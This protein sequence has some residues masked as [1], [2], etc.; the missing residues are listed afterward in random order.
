MGFDRPAVNRTA[1]EG[2]VLALT[3]WIL[4]A[5]A[6]AVGLATLWALD[7][8]RNASAERFRVEDQLAMASTRDT[9]IYLG[10]TRQR[11]RA[12]L[13]VTVP[14]G[15]EQAL[16]SLDDLGG[17]SADPVGGELRL[18]GRPYAGLGGTT[19]SIQDE[20]GLFVLASPS[21]ASLDGFLAWAGVP[22]DK[23]AVLRD[24][25]LDYTD[26]D[27]LR[28]LNGAEKR[29]YERTSRPPP[30]NRRLLLPA[31]VDRILGWNAL[32]QALREQL[33]E[34]STTF[35]SGALNLNTV[36]E[37]LLPAWIPG[38]PANCRRLVE[39]RDQLPFRFASDVELL[40]GIRLPGD[41]GVD[42]RF[43][44]DD[45]LRFTFWSHSGAAWRIHVRFTPLADQVGPWSVLA[46]HP[47]SRPGND[48][49]A[50]PTGSDLFADEAVDRP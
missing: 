20:A 11:T 22:R 8:V 43:L 39:R 12:G 36:P 19:F 13:A 21:N 15:A 7:A 9:L 48:A 46:L 42:Y 17:L 4:A 29:E 50:R 24:A 41:P 47:T 10:A 27:G 2:F 40:L 35:Y 49:P 38:C 45:T 37:S 25:F 6:V 30:P 18:D 33:P 16:R 5:I 44:A 32:P 28:R 23:I 14:T 34:I 1:E 31:E 3:L 26:A